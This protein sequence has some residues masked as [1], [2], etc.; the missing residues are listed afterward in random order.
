M[1]ILFFHK[2]LLEEGLIK[3]LGPSEIEGKD[4]GYAIVA[5]NFL[6]K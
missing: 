1:I 5:D 6:V 2:L 4:G 3:D